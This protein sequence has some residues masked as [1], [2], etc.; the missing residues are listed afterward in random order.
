MTPLQVIER[1][2]QE[3]QQALD[4]TKSQQERNRLG[5]FATPTALADDIMAYAKQLLPSRG[6]IRF[7]DPAL[8][9]GSFYSALRRAI[10]QRRVTSA[11]GFEIDPAFARAAQHLWSQSGLLVVTGDFTKC[12][13]PRDD[14]DKVTL[15]VTNPPYVRHH[16]LSTTDKARLQVLVANATGLQLSGLSGLYCYFLLL[17]H[18]WMARGAIASW[19][20]PTEFLDVNYGATIKK[21]LLSRVTLLRI[22]RFDPND[23]QFDDALVSSAVVWFRNEPSPAEHTVQFTYGG[24]HVHPA[25]RKDIPATVL[26]TEAKWSRLFNGEAKGQTNSP[27][28]ADLFTIRR[29]IATGSNTFFIITREEAT[30][31]HLPEA[32]LTPILPSP[33]HLQDDEVLAD[34]HGMPTIERQLVLINCTLAEEEVAHRYP[35]LASYLEEGKAQG[36]HEAYLCAH[37]NPWY[38]Q[39]TRPAPPFLC[40]Y[41]GRGEKDRPFRFILNHSRATAANVYLLLYPRPPLERLLREDP[42]NAQRVWKALNRLPAKTLMG[43]G[44]V[45]GGGLYKLEPK[46][47]ANAPADTI[48]DAL[49]VLRKHLSVQ[50]RLFDES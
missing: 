27:T 30:R 44:R 28:I 35:R 23:V 42:A 41:M 22:H 11:T 19:L 46:E 21:Y 25:R 33:R 13:P 26:A 34:H 10:P 40:T 36:I 24:T 32:V 20:I 3:R 15:L 18:P 29:G 49:P 5:Q 39:E 45:Y 17:A 31:R 50:I 6:E 1:A 9:T 47:L 37:R 38:A 2:R 12:Q 48:L 8:G 16:H 43:E 7:M 4:A 14:H